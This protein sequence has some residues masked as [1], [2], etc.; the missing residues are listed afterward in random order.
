MDAQSINK[1]SL[2]NHLP[3]RIIL[4][5]FCLFTVLL[6]TITVFAAQNHTIEDNGRWS[7]KVS[8]IDWTWDPDF[9]FDLKYTGKKIFWVIPVPSLTIG[10][11]MEIGIAGDFDLD[12]KQANL[13]AN[14]TI[15]SP[16]E[17]KPEDLYRDD[18]SDTF[19]QYMP[20]VYFMGFDLKSYLVAGASQP[21][22]VKGKFKNTS[23]LSI[24]TERGLENI[25]EPNFEFTSVKPKTNEN[26]VVFVG[27][28]MEEILKV[29]EVGYRGYSIGPL[30][31]GNIGMTAGVKASAV[32]HKDEW[33]L[34]NA[35]ARNSIHSCT[36]V[37]RPGCVDGESIQIK[38]M[39]VDLRARLELPLI[40]YEVYNKNWPLDHNYCSY[41]RRHFVQSLTWNEKVKYQDVCKHYYYK[42]PVAVWA[43][44][45]KS[46]PCKGV[47]VQ[48]SNYSDSDPNV[49]QLCT[50][51]TGEDGKTSIYL[52]Y[53]NGKYTI[54]AEPYN[55]DEPYRR[56]KGTGEQPTPMRRGLND[57]VDIILESAVKDS[58]TVKKEWDIDFEE[59]DKPESI[60]VLLQ[61]QY[62][63]TGYIS[64]EG[65]ARATLNSA[66]NWTHT[67]QEV[68]RYEMNAKGEMVEIKYRIRELKEKSSG[69][70]GQGG[71]DGQDGGGNAQGAGNL[72][73]QVADIGVVQ[74]PN[75]LYH[76]DSGP[77][78]EDSKRVVP[79]RW[80][81]DNTHIWETVKKKTTDWNELWQFEPTMNYAKRFGKEAFF[82]IPSVT[83]KVKEY[84]TSVGEHVEAHT[85]KYMVEYDTSDDGKTTTIK[86]TAIMDITMYKRWIMFKGAKEP[87]YVYLALCYRPQEKYRELVAGTAAED[88]VGLWIPVFNPVNGYKVNIMSLLGGIIGGTAGKVLDWIA[89]V[90]VAN[91]LSFPFAVGKVSK[92]EKLGNPLNAWRVSFQVR[93]YGFVG[94][95]GVPVE[96]QSMELTSVI[97]TDVIKF[98][99]GFD[100][101]ISFSLNASG[102][103]YI[104]VPSKPR[105]IPLLD[106]D[107]ERTANVINTWTKIN[108]DNTEE[109]A[110]GGTKYWVGDKEE[111]RP[112]SLTIVVQ[113]EVKE[114]EEESAV[115]TKKEVGR[116]TIKKEDNKGK[117]DWVWALKE[118]D[119]ADGVT[120]D[121]DKTYIITEEYP[122]GYTKKDNYTCSVDKHDLT[123]TWADEVRVVI[124]KKYDT[125]LVNKTNYFPEC[126]TFKIKDG[127]GNPVGRE[128]GYS[129]NRAYEHA[130]AGYA[131]KEGPITLID[132]PSATDSSEEDIYAVSGLK[133]IDLSKCTI[134][135]TYEYDDNRPPDERMTFYPKVDGPV[136]DTQKDKND[137]IVCTCTF[138][139]TNRV[140]RP[141]VINIRKKWSGDENN[142]S[143]RPESVTM[144]LKREGKEIG[145]VELRRSGS[146]SSSADEWAS[147]PI[148]RDN[149]G[150]LLQYM[151]PDTQE[152]YK[153]TV[154][155]ENV[156]S[157][158]T[159]SVEM[160]ES[161]QQMSEIRTTINFT[162][163]N[164][165]TEPIKDIVT[166]KG[167][168]T[169]DDKDN[170][171]NL[172][173]Q[174]IV[175]RLM[176]GNG[177]AVN[178]DG[179][180]IDQTVSGPDWNWEFTGLP[181]YDANGNEISY[182]V[183]E[184]TVKATP[185]GDSSNPA[186]DTPS[187]DP[188]PDADPEAPSSD[189]AD[190]FTSLD[191]YT[192][193]YADP[194]FD[195]G[196]KTWTCD[197]TNSTEKTNVSVVKVWDDNDNETGLRPDEV[198]IRLIAN[199]EETSTEKEIIQLNSEN[200]WQ[201][202]FRM[203]PA[204]EDGKKITYSIEED[205]VDSYKTR[206]TTEDGANFTVTNSIDDSLINI[207][208]TKVWK[209]DEGKEDDRP[210]YVTVN[211]YNGD[212][213]VDSITVY[214]SNG[215]KGAFRGIPKN[216]ADDQP[217]S[218]TVKEDKVSGYAEP[219]ISGSAEEGFTVTNTFTGKL[220]ITVRK[221]WETYDGS[222]VNISYIVFALKRNGENIP[223]YVGLQRLYKN[224]GWTKTYTDFPKYDD[225]G[226]K[227]TYS[228]LENSPVQGFVID[229]DEYAGSSGPLFIIRHKQEYREITVTKIWD[230]DDNALGRRPEYAFVHLL[231]DGEKVIDQGT[232]EEDHHYLRGINSLASPNDAT[233]AR[234]PVYKNDG[235]GEKT[236]IS[237][238]VEEDPVTGYL[239]SITGNME[240]GFTITNT[241]I[242][243]N[244]D[245]TVKKVW[246]DDSNHDKNRPESVTVRLYAD[247][248]EIA[249]AQV[250]P[251]EGETLDSSNT[252]SYTFTDLP[253][254]D[255]NG[256]GENNPGENS[257]PRVIQYTV[258]EDPVPGYDTEVSGTSAD[259]F[260]ITNTQ[261]KISVS[262]KKIWD[263]GNESE[264]VS[265]DP[266]TVNLYKDEAMLMDYHQVKLEK[267]KGWQHTWNDL[268]A[269]LNG[270][271]VP[272]NVEEDP[273]PDGYMAR[274]TGS[275]E[276]GFTI[277]NSPIPTKTDIKVTKEWI[278]DTEPAEKVTV[279]LL[280]DQ[281]STGNKEEV[282]RC[283]LTA[284]EGWTHTF[285]DMPVYAN[286][287]DRVIDYSVEEEPLEGYGDPFYVN[288]Q[289]DFVIQNWKSDKTVVLVNKFWSGD[290]E[291]ERPDKIT[292]NLKKNGE[293]CDSKTITKDDNWETAFGD[294]DRLDQSGSLIT[295]TVE[296]EAVDG[297]EGTIESSTDNTGIIYYIKITNTK[298]EPAG[299]KV[300]YSVGGDVPKDYKAPAGRSD[301]KTGS[302][303]TV[304]AAPDSREGTKDGVRGTYSFAGWT[305]PE[306]V[307]VTDGSFKM[308]NKD[309][310][311]TGV[312]TFTA[313]TYDV[314]YVIYGDKPSDSVKPDDQKNIAAGTPMDMPADLT[315]RDTEK[316]GVPG[317]WTFSGW[318][319]SAPEG[320]TPSGGKYTMP[321]AN[322]TISASWSF[323]PEASED[324]YTLTDPVLPAT[325][326]PAVPESVTITWLNYDGTLIEKTEVAY[327]TTPSHAAPALV[328]SAEGKTYTFQGWTPTVT[329]ATEDTAYTAQFLEEDNVS[330]HQTVIPVPT[331]VTPEDR[332]NEP[333]NHEDLPEI[334]TKKHYYEIY[335]I[336]TGDYAAVPVDPEDESQGTRD[337]LSNIVWGQNGRDPNNEN[338]SVGD[339]VDQSVLDA[340]ASVVNKE[341]DR[342]KLD[343]IEQYLTI[344]G[345]PYRTITLGPDDTENSIQLPPGY[346]LIRD[347]DTSQT[348]RHDA[349]TT[350]ITV[351]IKDYVINPKSVIPT[352]DKQVYDNYDGANRE[353]WA[354][355]ADHNINESFRFALIGTIPHNSHLVDY[356]NGYFVKFTDTMS[357]GVTFESIDKVTVNETEVAASDYTV[358]GVEA[359]DAGKTWT[360][361][362][363]VRSIIGEKDFGSEGISVIVTYNAHLNENAIVHRASDDGE[364]LDNTNRNS[365]F[366]EYSNNP[367][368]GYGVDTGR[369]QEDSVWVF[370][371]EITNI[372][373]AESENGKPLAGAGFTLLKDGTEV[374]LNKYGTD[375]IVADQTV[376]E[377]LVTE[378]ITDETG[379]FNVWGL[380]AGTYILR[381]TTVP[382]GYNSPKVINLSI[383]A[384][385]EES[386]LGGSAKL[387]L[388]G[389][390]LNNT[391]VNEPGSSLPSTGGRGTALYYIA[392]LILI[393]GSGAMLANRSRNLHDLP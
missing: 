353:G 253:V 22:A 370:T 261:Q 365:V 336:F 383:I 75:G 66:N 5:F 326:Q 210:D 150:N 332:D 325:S 234:C 225:E 152:P 156:P 16:V 13:P 194:V 193:F 316:D 88:V 298:T 114:G 280:S 296:E 206:I 247:D 392:G 257:Q 188:A 299:H 341:L 356:T 389:N 7:G 8:N 202:I 291:S 224:E 9:D 374:K 189:I 285:K 63:N 43:N 111:D 196:T 14:T 32:L 252:W 204:K 282:A 145:W 294:L 77:L 323:D 81:L 175:I 191:G 135:E 168:K 86:N 25:Y 238:T 263:D 357:P 197:I 151:N 153:Y 256:Q 119:T 146:G 331:P 273:V 310:E 272:W 241:L 82:P 219:E 288:G 330:E 393:L 163:T 320:L 258:V 220:D 369:T 201:H 265:H 274:I 56:A 143:G 20:A 269:Y 250:G 38:D 65:V 240:D 264:P 329:A 181:R 167:T 36:E 117:N 333:T 170:E 113:E 259:G 136:I 328:P 185:G 222:D 6:M 300:T 59:K 171:D 141:V 41:D 102:D 35:R 343:V 350:Y 50:G 47:Y 375:Y 115:T 3:E 178:K 52:P 275:I 284:A 46:I 132:S 169:W 112:D 182:R 366:M 44:K 255:G 104:S 278:D 165:L 221:V 345:H 154:E 355:T 292:I 313:D 281:T 62:Y 73:D 100:C 10:F 31:T 89:K 306:G 34:E 361:W 184:G 149:H 235:D 277:T 233:F 317:T 314:T 162:V 391:I 339:P 118:S 385:H 126:L 379:V 382:E 15:N 271:E 71:Q 142:K 388:T 103:K 144:I 39:F 157:G 94:V 321:A 51:K 37:G 30:M 131:P 161:P 215:W 166:V 338:V 327:K 307:T 55:S 301:V 239:T 187:G 4:G 311:F 381:E 354:E 276:E 309:V 211:L 12:L 371:Y 183:V 248:K 208:V 179:K 324:R 283:I 268:P 362:M 207:P 60:E 91:L 98:L 297:Y 302:S 364:T 58:Y 228:V 363:N 386:P 140:Q 127:N 308:P 68:P 107:W 287:G 352:V 229:I 40:D 121:P 348:G 372:K 95:P 212:E 203:L 351:V 29:G 376:S 237:Y 226:N 262:V 11:E 305:A 26:T 45:N 290:E 139:V 49:S 125:N 342:E 99:T 322:V 387:N 359:G 85:T 110:I 217:I 176:T 48:N 236:F 360:I 53:K 148:E 174:S 377:G 186:P 1:K 90:D 105:Q 335:Q 33:S 254:L 249:S 319:I 17:K 28:T 92:R 303:V 133:G 227:Y 97:V 213:L 164:T 286:N 159:S 74:A 122:E 346:Y 155:E 2:N 242:R 295:Y 231:V 190:G 172:R 200:N 123:N 108:S 64:W 120:L 246:K 147:S 67:F 344:D 70:D 23:K 384:S 158:Y 251:G 129:L 54:L 205:P 318:T 83:F 21:V 109:K 80:D 289:Y 76:P 137:R 173:P 78:A 198:N 304:E 232:G 134:E 270:K 245:I 337:V 378:I 199:T 340:L 243:E 192:V 216:D 124:R 84:D 93:K 373:K 160:K 180:Y 260:T 358:T 96:Y 19:F 79:S 214:K 42:I 334:T 266:V 116:T 72:I 177:P 101:P 230:D 279:I 380:D 218:Y 368:T 315:T 57:Q 138:T 18:I 106:K 61:A 69:G 293:V 128:S 209:G 195:A 87:D 244:K 267:S 130:Y 27:A 223:G 349:Y 312:W 347:T 24:T 390:G 367:N